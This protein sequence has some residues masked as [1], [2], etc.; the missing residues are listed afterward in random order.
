MRNSVSIHFLV[1]FRQEG[2]WWILWGRDNS[3]RKGD[4]QLPPD[5]SLEGYRSVV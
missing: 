5:F 2:L 1:T 4:T 3:I